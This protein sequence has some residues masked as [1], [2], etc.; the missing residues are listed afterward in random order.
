M[1]FH[2]PH[3]D[4]KPAVLSK[5]RNRDFMATLFPPDWVRVGWQ[6]YSDFYYRQGEP[7]GIKGLCAPGTEAL[8]DFVKGWDP[9]DSQD[10]WVLILPRNPKKSL[11][12]ETWSDAS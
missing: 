4:A 5:Q 2:K 12:E 3:P 10:V 8:A 7:L 6:D 1:S 11:K 9:G